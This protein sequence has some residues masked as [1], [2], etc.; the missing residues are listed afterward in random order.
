MLLVAIEILATTQLAG[1]G[2]EMRTIEQ[3]IAV[4][5]QE[6]EILAQ[7]VA[8]ASSLLTVS[9]RAKELGMVDVAPKQIIP[10]GPGTIRVA[11]GHLQ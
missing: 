1:S 5:K 10:L 9:V 7:E 3:R 11:L 2:Q 6:N 4:V 8:S